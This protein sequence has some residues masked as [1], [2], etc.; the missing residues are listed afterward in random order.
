MTTIE[1][2]KKLSADET[3]QAAELL[4]QGKIVAFPTETVYGLGA[5]IFLPEA[6]KKIFLAKG[7]PAD[8]PLIAHVSNFS[9]IEEITQNIPNDFLP[10]YNAFFPGPLSIVLEKAEKVP[11]I[12]SGGINTI[13]FRMPNHPI[14]LA[15]IEK[16]GQP[17]VAPSANISGKP[18]STQFSHVLDDF[19]GKIGAIV[20]GS[21]SEIG[22]ESTVISLINNTPIILRPGH[23][24][25]EA[26][27]AVLNKKVALTNNDKLSNSPVSSPGMKY[28]H[29]APNAPTKLFFSKKELV[30]YLNS[31]PNPSRLLL[32]PSPL[33]EAKGCNHFPLSPKTLYAG[34]RKADSDGF[35]EVLIL[36]NDSI[37]NDQALMN[38]LFRATEEAP[39]PLYNRAY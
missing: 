34:L 6:I 13:A 16:V 15:I 14:A 39:F 22:I 18:S 27:E 38:R 28:R 11:S 30:N 36:C 10:L 20:E 24:T 8:N 31:N 32:S 17:I 29:Y 37:A 4:L 26:I 5:C 12:V 21:S 7:R 35:S 9:Q 19:D 1:I 23:I 33:S 3:S 25:K 2:T